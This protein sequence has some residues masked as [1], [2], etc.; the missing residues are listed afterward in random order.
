VQRKKLYSDILERFIN[1]NVT[2]AALREIDRYGGVDEYL[3][4]AP[5]LES[6]TGEK[7]KKILEFKIKSASR[8]GQKVGIDL[9]LDKHSQLKE[10]IETSTKTLSEGEKLAKLVSE[11]D[12]TSNS[13]PN[14]N[15]SPQELR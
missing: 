3:L 5:K 9:F 1:I 13:L 10:T 15:A 8:T 2:S 14:S 6:E 7:L 11:I 4:N 12:Q